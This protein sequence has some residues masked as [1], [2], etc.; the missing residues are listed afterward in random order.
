MSKATK[1]VK[2]SPEQAKAWLEFKA[3]LSCYN[4]GSTEGLHGMAKRLAQQQHDRLAIETSPELAAVAAREGE[5][6]TVKGV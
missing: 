3:T 5:Y 4:S 2:M 1:Q 6:V